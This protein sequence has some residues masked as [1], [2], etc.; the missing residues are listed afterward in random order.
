M[1]PTLNAAEQELDKILN[2]YGRIYWHAMS[3]E[4]AN[5]ISPS[6]AETTKEAGRDEAKQALLAWRQSGIDEAVVAEME[7]IDAANKDNGLIFWFADYPE[8]SGWVTMRKYTA[9]RIAQLK[10]NKET[11]Q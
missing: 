9:F 5:V 11:K 4:V 3:N 2:T 7:R 8:N 1:T 6:E 10:S